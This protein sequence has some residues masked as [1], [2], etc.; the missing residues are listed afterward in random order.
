MEAPPDQD[1]EMVMISSMA[2]LNDVKTS[3]IRS[4]PGSSTNSLASSG[5]DVGLETEGMENTLE[6]R[7]KAVH[8]TDGSKPISLWHD[9][10]L[11]HID[12]ETRE[13]TPFFNFVC[14]IPKFTR[15]V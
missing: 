5:A 9:I 1:E 10:S 4:R 11:V 12:H 14:E 15:Y 13:P 7:L 6:F 3:S 2:P 8:A